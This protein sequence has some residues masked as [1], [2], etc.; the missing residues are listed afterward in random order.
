VLFLNYFFS[1]TDVETRD[2]NNIFYENFL[3]FHIQFSP[4]VV[5]GSG[6]GEK[7]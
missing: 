6:G 5:G 1:L 2:E 4:P 3:S 7:R